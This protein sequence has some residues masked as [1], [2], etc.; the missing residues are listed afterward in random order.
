L[1]RMGFQNAFNLTSVLEKMGR[2]D[3]DYRFMAASDLLAELKKETF[4]LDSTQE[5]KVGAAV[6]KLLVDELSGDVQTQAQHCLGPLVKKVSTRETGSLIDKLI[7]SLFGAEKTNGR[8]SASYALKTIIIE[9]QP[10]A[11]SLIT[12]KLVPQLCEKLSATDTGYEV[13]VEILE[14]LTCAI[15]HYGNLFSS[16]SVYNPIKV[17][18]LKELESRRKNNRKR[19]AQCLAN[20]AVAMEPS[21]FKEFISVLV[22]TATTSKSHE[23]IR[24]CIQTIGSVS[25]SAGF[26]LADCMDQVAPIVIT[27]A[28]GEHLSRGDDDE[29][30]DE[31]RENCFQTL[32]SLIVRCPNTIPPFLDSITELCLEYI[33][34]DPNYNEDAMMDDEF[35]M[36]DGFEDFDEWEEEEIDYSDDEDVSWK[37][38]KAASKTLGEI[39]RTR[40]DMTLHLCSSVSPV[41]ISRFT[42]REE[43]VKLDVFKTFS[44][45]LKQIQKSNSI[46]ATAPQEN[47]E[48]QVSLIIDQLTKILS[49]KNLKNKVRIGVFVLLKELVQSASLSVATRLESL[50]PS[51]QSALLDKNATSNLKIETL[52]FLRLLLSLSG[53]NLQSAAI[54]QLIEPI[55]TCVSDNYYKITAESL[56]V[57]SALIPVLSQNFSEYS[58]SIQQMYAVLLPKLK[59]QDIDQEVK[60]EVIH[61]AALLITNVGENL[62]DSLNECFLIL[63]DRLTNEI[64]R[65]TTV[66]ALELIAKSHLHLDLSPILLSS[67]T[68]LTGFLRL[69]NRQLKQS[70]LNTLNVFFCSQKNE[71]ME[72]SL[73]SL[74]E[75]VA[76]L[77]SAEDLHLTHLAL[78]LAASI[79]TAFPTCGKMIKE[80]VFPQVLL[81]LQSKVLQGHALDN[82][83]E[84]LKAILATRTTG[85]GFTHISKAVNHLLAKK[86]LSKK[87]YPACAQCIGVLCANASEKKRAGVL[88]G[89]V[90][91]ISSETST[92]QQSIVSLLCIGEIGRRIDFCTH[93]K[94]IEEIISRAFTATSEEIKSAAAFSLGNLAVGN[95]STFLPFI[96]NEIETHK[97]RQYLLLV[98]LREVI[99]RL[100]SSPDRVGELLDLLKQKNSGDALFQYCQSSKEGICNVVAECVGR[101]AIIDKENM[102]N[103][104][105]SK[106]QSD[107]PHDRSTACSSLKFSIGDGDQEIIELLSPQ[108]PLFLNL[109]EDQEVDVRRAALLSFNFLVHNRPALVFEYLEKYMPMVYAETKENSNLLRKVKVGPFTHVVDDGLENRKAAFECMYT[110]M[111]TCLSHVNVSTFISH[112]V[113]GLD[114][115]SADIKS[116]CH[117]M[118][119]H[120]ATSDGPAVVQALD[121]VVDPLR[122]TLEKKPKE[123]AVKQDKE[124]YE[125]LVRSSLRAIIAISRIPGADTS[126]KFAEFLN[127][128]VQSGEIREKYAAMKDSAS[129]LDPMD[130]SN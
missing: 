17:E 90:T 5:K 113:S 86:D 91:Q 41:L 92:E 7:E 26:R 97:E 127:T 10:Q 85:F 122:V 42:E 87:C 115:N 83:L 117:I 37:V 18:V 129:I 58:E 61:C 80:L 14:V 126:T 70:S 23:I 82:I 15:S 81:L 12:S 31:L 45:L 52:T 130:V 102:L 94:G 76:P 32:E 19:A 119:E 75:N 62:G 68:Q 107:S 124:R 89:L 106:L 34:Y 1:S 105:F 79:T 59:A 67:I 93:T 35:E 71:K 128:T 69:N 50:L 33:K 46:G 44:L 24:S 56:R 39:I 53:S 2:S 54:K 57:C 120:L 22:K 77:I 13:K 66:K 74:L 29:P 51:I 16:P 123:S 47:M 25:R 114:D 88:S 11:N 96:L 4:K 40:S 78:Q 36:E 49:D 8:D 95:L 28:K 103:K 30:D 116:M 48:K 9:M 21:D 104:I 60:E 99:S 64:T 111:E 72:E 110:L 27:C 121:S 3:S 112:L 63:E 55:C 65:L 38:R 43:T 101:L 6:L 109:L 108:I 73:R 100:S 84:L 98:S 118:L 20:L 125:E